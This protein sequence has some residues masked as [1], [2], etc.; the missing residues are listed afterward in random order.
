M[1]F[2]YMI[3]RYDLD[4]RS[5]YKGGRAPRKLIILTK[6]D[7]AEILGVSK[8]HLD[9]LINQGNLKL[10][11]DPVKDFLALHAFCNARDVD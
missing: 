10:T 5:R 3:N 6:D 7:V 4:A 9:R 2:N 11:G 1:P 8:R